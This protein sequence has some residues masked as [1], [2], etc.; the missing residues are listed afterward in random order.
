MMYLI[1]ILLLLYDNYSQPFAQ[2]QFDSVKQEL[3]EQFGGV[4]A[5]LRAPAEGAWK[6]DSGAVNRDQIVI[7]EVMV[8][9]PGRAWWAEYRAG[10]A[11]SFQ[12]E[13]MVVRAIPI[14]CL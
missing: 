9:D 2:E 5:Y 3:T 1:Q 7:L 13:E 4:T 6:E 8:S 14:E 11:R 10:L 12:Q